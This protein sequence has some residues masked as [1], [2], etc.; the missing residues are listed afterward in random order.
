MA[1]QSIKPTLWSKKACDVVCLAILL[2]TARVRHG[3]QIVQTTSGW[4]QGAEEDGGECVMC[5]SASSNI[6]L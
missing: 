3:Q 4:M 2:M 5:L 1:S 6:F